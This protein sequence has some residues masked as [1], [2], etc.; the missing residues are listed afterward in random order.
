[1]SAFPRRDGLNVHLVPLAD[2]TADSE[3]FKEV[4]TFGPHCGDGSPEDHRLQCA[5][6]P[7]RPLGHAEYLLIEV[8]Q[9]DGA[10]MRRAGSPMTDHRRRAFYRRG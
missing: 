1:M 9:R 4:A 5:V 7:D 2:I 6:R 8:L 10:Q 3:G